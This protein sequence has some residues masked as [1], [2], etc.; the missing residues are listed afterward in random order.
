ME[1]G[2]FQ[3]KTN[4]IIYGNFSKNYQFHSLPTGSKERYTHC[5]K[6]QEP[7][8]YKTTIMCLNWK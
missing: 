6:P 5:L 1:Q 7:W 4:L 2:M 3:S 8:E